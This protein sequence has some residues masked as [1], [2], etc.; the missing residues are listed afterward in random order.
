M[1]NKDVRAPFVLGAFICIGLVLLG[2]LLADGVTKI[3]ALSRTVEVKGL[4][5]REV[6]A[7][8][9]IWPIKFRE[10]DNDLN[11][12]FSTVQRKNAVIIDFLKSQGFKDDEISAAAPSV[13]D[14]R[15][16]R[17]EHAAYKKGEGGFDRRILPDGLKSLRPCPPTQRRQTASRGNLYCNKLSYMLAYLHEMA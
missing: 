12:L 13:V 1:N 15:G 17:H 2:F 3:R 11:T 7:N 5:E 8:V 4:S 14:K 10:A 16:S 6:P 9:A